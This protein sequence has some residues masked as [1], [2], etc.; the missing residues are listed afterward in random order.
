[1]FTKKSLFGTLSRFL[2][3]FQLWWQRELANIQL[4]KFTLDSTGYFCEQAN[5]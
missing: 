4:L 1:M 5:A 2:K 3:M